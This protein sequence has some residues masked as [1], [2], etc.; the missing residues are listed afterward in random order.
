M[1]QLADEALEA[2][3]DQLSGEYEDREARDL[4]AERMLKAHFAPLAAQ[5]DAMLDR[6]FERLE[7]YEAA[8]L[9]KLADK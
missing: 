6:F 5:A 8:L 7:A 1:E 2:H 9:S 4:A 3:A